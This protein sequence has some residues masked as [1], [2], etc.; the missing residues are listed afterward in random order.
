MDKHTDIKPTFWWVNPW[1]YAHSLHRA[2]GAVHRAWNDEISR[3]SDKD[4]TIENLRIHV[5]ALESKLEARKA[6][7]TDLVLSSIAEGLTAKQAVEKYGFKEPTAR[8][9]ASS[10]GLA[11]AWAGN[12]R[13][14]K[15]VCKVE[16][17]RRG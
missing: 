12:G 6:S 5:R 13:K 3:S 16:G 1:A 9:I 14:P 17:S 11:F 2:L 8:A 15:N 7:V 10:F 4:R